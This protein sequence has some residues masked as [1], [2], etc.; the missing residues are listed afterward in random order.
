MRAARRILCGLALV[1]ATTL[2]RA[3]TGN[4]PYLWLSDIHGAKAVAWA[5]AQT[6]KS[7]AILKASPLYQPAYDAIQKSLDAKDHLPLAKLNHND[8]YN[9]WQDG[10]HVR[11]LWR[12]TTIADYASAHPHWQTLIGLD[13]LDAAEHVDWVWQGDDCAPDG[14][15]CL[16]QLSPG[17]GDAAT[18]REFSLKAKSFVKN[19]FAL[20]QAKLNATYLDA[21]TVLFD[22]DFGPGTLTK[23]GY[24]RM[25]KL[26]HRGE[27]IAAAKL[28]YTA[29]AG[30]VSARP[31]VFRG[32][33]GTLAVIERDPTFFTSEY[34]VVQ[35]DGTTLKLP[36][37][38]G[39]ILHGVTGGQMIFSLRDAWAPP[40]AAK[41]FP[42][43]ALIAFDALPYVVHK[44]PAHFALLYA[45]TATSTVE[46][47]GAGRDA[48]YAAIFENVVGTI[49]AFHLN[50]GEWSDTKLAMPGGGSTGVVATNAWG[51]EAQFT[52][53]SYLKPPTLYA[54]DG[55]TAPKAI[56][57]Q[58]PVFDA[59]NIAADQYW[60]TSTDGTKIPYFLIHR[61]DQ[62]GPAPT[63]LYS[64]GGFETVFV[65]RSIGMTA[66]ARWRPG[67][68]SITAV[69]WPSPISAAAA[70]S[71]RPGMRRR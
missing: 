60:A 20:P 57:A 71:A 66:I 23:S 56:K 24:P 36:L 63:I 70:S 3:D 46:D 12:R 19:G 33:Y 53:E 9:F 39:A 8:A 68:G 38:A 52:F 67:C 64:Y 22:T 29:E 15:H 45:P 7:D 30:D 54:T 31:I 35:P 13:R 62:K 21:D 61:K 41:P 65:S 69:R 1:A 25:V 4:D 59:G 26:W 5:K 44:S 50:N 16:I 47:V 43:G 14:D 27:P 2:A 34:Q 49:H 28:I 42:Q 17:G 11:G 18:I 10:A 37:P 32:P 6:D 48:V 58:A 51:P 55:V 40:G